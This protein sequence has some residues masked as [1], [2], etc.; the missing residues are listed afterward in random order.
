[1]TQ[2][3]ISRGDILSKISQKKISQREAAEILGISERQVRRLYVKFQKFGISSLV[4][5]KRKKPSNNQLPPGL[6]IQISELITIELYSGFHPKYM[7]EKLY[8]LHGIKVSIETTRKL[9]I[10]NDVW[11]AHKKKSPVIHQQRKRRARCGELIQIDGSPH[12]WFEERGDSCVLIS[13]VDDATGQTYGRFFKTET[14]KAYMITLWKYFLK[15]GRPLAFYSDR[16][17][18]FRI[19]RPGCLKKDLITQFARACKE[20]DIQTIC[21]N[22]P[23][24]KGRVERNNRTQQDR[25][26]KELRLAGI[27]TMDEANKFLDNVYWDIYNKQFAVLPESPRDAHRELLPEHNLEKI[28]SCKKQ[29]TLSKNLEVQSDN[30]IYQIVLKNP[31][32]KLRHAKVT[33]I[34]AINGRVYIEHNGKNL[35]FKIFS[36]QKAYGNIVN[37]KQ[38]DTFLKEK[39]TRKVPHTHPWKQQGRAEARKKKHEAEIGE[40]V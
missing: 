8:E 3:E 35:P 28:L 7:C 40:V 32:W 22:S 30:I 34:K 39:K 15:Y 13:F 36:E 9:M 10:Q 2:A 19:N 20:L 17:S 29:G 33:I 27:N 14:T 5:Q 38:I 25:L 31:S 6:K 18:I 11:V 24:A 1:M 23:Q 21:A 16:H 37:P 12:A 26:V 4:S